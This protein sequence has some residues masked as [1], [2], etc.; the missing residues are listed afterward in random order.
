RGG[1]GYERYTHSTR[2]PGASDAVGTTA[3]AAARVGASAPGVAAVP[4]TAAGHRPR[5]TITVHGGGSI[6]P[7]A[8]VPAWPRGATTTAPASRIQVGRSRTTS[9]TDGRL[10]GLHGAGD[11][12]N[13]GSTTFTPRPCVNS[14]G[15]RAAPPR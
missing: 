14:L 1:C 15:R 12:R 5:T 2:R 13:T 7:H 6:R 11:V 10:A 9:P 3:A 8:T 4:A